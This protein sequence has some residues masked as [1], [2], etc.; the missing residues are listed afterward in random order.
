MNTQTIN[1]VINGEPWPVQ[2]SRTMT[3]ATLM[4]RALQQRPSAQPD[5]REWEVRLASGY[6]LGDYSRVSVIPNGEA[7]FMN[8]KAGVAA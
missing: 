7:V 5:W 1:L 8:L 2:V 4:R 6:R 3:I